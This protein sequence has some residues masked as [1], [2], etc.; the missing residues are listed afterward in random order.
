ML[1]SLFNKVVGPQACNFIKERL[2]HRCFPV[3]HA[4]VLR[5]PSFKNSQLI[6]RIAFLMEVIL[7][8]LKFHTRHC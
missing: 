2:Q 4:N 1:E 8:F 3:I 5:T 7:V 6:V